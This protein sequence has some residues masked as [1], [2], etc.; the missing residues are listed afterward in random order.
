MVRGV[1]M[2]YATRVM[3][4]Y[5]ATLGWSLVR[6]DVDD[7]NSTVC[8]SITDNHRRSK[9]ER[10]TRETTVGTGDR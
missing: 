2:H 3:E 4:R 1:H 7:A 8:I 10:G 6:G 9:R 5:Y